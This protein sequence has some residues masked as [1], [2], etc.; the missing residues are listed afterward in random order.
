MTIFQMSTLTKVDGN[1]AEGTLPSSTKVRGLK[2]L[3]TQAIQIFGSTNFSK[4]T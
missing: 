4:Y 2:T 3:I 1:Q